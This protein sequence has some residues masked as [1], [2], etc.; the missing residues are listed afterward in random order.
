LTQEAFS[1]LSLLQGETRANVERMLDAPPSL[2]AAP[3]ECV[4]FAYG[5]RV[6]L[7]ALFREGTLRHIW[8]TEAPSVPDACPAGPVRNVAIEA[9]SWYPARAASA[10]PTTRRTPSS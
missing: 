8:V 7:T 4:R 3:D 2:D 9:R 5:P 10:G 1:R 6:G